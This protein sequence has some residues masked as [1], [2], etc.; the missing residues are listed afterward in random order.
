VK[1]DAQTP[2]PDVARAVCT[3]LHRVGVTAVL[4]G[5]SA[6]TYYAPEAYQSKDI[7]FVVVA[8]DLDDPAA[9][10]ASLEAIGY[11]RELNY[12]RHTCSRYPIEFPPGPLGV[13]GDLVQDW[14]TEQRDGTVLHVLHP[15][16]CCKDRLAAFFHWA[17]R[18]ALEQAVAVAH[19]HAAELDFEG[20]REW[21][22]REGHLGR[23]EEFE[24]RVG[25]SQ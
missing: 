13:D 14:R 15:S 3:A 23:Y 16:D 19:A 5:G 18:S 4:T 25:R 12:Y 2:L 7:D 21:A 1:I 20:L 17:D 8:F 24:R 9:A 11:K 6:A 22:S 10:Q